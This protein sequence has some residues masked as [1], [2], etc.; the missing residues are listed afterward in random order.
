MNGKAPE[1]KGY[2]YKRPNV[3]RSNTNRL[4]GK[5]NG[6][7]AVL[8]ECDSDELRGW[9]CQMVELGVLTGCTPTSDGGALSISI[10][11]GSIT[12]RW[13]ARS[14]DELLA[15]FVATEQWILGEL[16]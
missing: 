15:I 4:R 7:I 14:A 9:L 13:Y 2:E 3:A 6:A 1:T 5:P 8:A 12:R 16:E 11:N 10:I